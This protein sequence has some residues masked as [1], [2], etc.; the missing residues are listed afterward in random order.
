MVIIFSLMNICGI[1]E[2]LPVSLKSLMLKMKSKSADAC[3][4]HLLYYN[5]THSLRH[6]A[7][8]RLNYLFSWSKYHCDDKKRFNF[9]EILIVSLCT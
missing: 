3:K 2:N 8:E 1:Y 6:L 9:P 7:I 5:S 4:I